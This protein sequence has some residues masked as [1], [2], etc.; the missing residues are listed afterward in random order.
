MRI[1]HNSTSITGDTETNTLLNMKGAT[2]GNFSH[3]SGELIFPITNDTGTNPNKMKTFTVS[4]TND[5]GLVD[6]F[7]RLNN[8]NTILIVGA[9]LY[10]NEGTPNNFTEGSAVWYGLK[11]S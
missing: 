7:C 3:I 11:K 6:G 2:G 10:N 1:A 5:D 9:R 4:Y 8:Q